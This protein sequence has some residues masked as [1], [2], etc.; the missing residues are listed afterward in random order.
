MSKKLYTL[1]QAGQFIQDLTAE[2]CDEI[3]LS[4]GSMSICVESPATPTF[5]TV[6]RTIDGWT[7]FWIPVKKDPMTWQLV[8]GANTTRTHKYALEGRIQRMVVDY[9]CTRD[10][11]ER[12][13]QAAWGIQYGYV[14]AV[15]RI[16]LEADQNR[17]LW[18]RFPGPSP[19]I[20]FWLN[21]YPK[22]ERVNHGKLVTANRIIKSLW[23]EGEVT[24]NGIKTLT[25]YN[26][27]HTHQI[28][29]PPLGRTTLATAWV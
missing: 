24:R 4:Q 10:L 1:T 12:Y 3:A 17:E 11:A 13:V 7:L 28:P 29:L 6:G 8:L 26:D 18:D 5:L 22:Y 16:V 2:D 20:R 9:G 15:I 19:A 23:G 21:A 25:A 14:D 27:R